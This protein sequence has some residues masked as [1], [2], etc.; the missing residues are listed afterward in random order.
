MSKYRIAR[1]LTKK[2]ETNNQNI[3]G[4]VHVC[5]VYELRDRHRTFG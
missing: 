4:A 5:F 1:N 2:E 3:R